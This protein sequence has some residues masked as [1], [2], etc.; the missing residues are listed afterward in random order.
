MSSAVVPNPIWNVH[1][2]TVVTVKTGV[3]SSGW[4]GGTYRGCVLAHLSG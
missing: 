2:A 3:R 4:F 1:W